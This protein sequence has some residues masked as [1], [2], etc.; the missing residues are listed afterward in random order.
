MTLISAGLGCTAGVRSSSGA[1][2]GGAGATPVTGAGASK[3]GSTGTGSGGHSSGDIGIT[4][5]GANPD[6]AACQ[7][8]DV[9]FTPQTPT[10]FILVDKSG[11]EFIS[12]T[13]GT[14]FNL[15][16]AVEQVVM[17][18]QDQVRFGLGSFVGDHA[19]G[20]CKLNF[21]S[22]PI[23][24]NNYAAIKSAYD[25][26]GPLMPFGSKADTPMAEAIVMVRAALKADTTSGQKYMMVVTDSETDFCDDGNHLCPGDA[27]TGLIQQMY[28]ETPSIGTLVIGLPSEQSQISTPLLKNFANAGAGQP[29][30]LP[31]GSGAATP[32]DVYYQCNGVAPWMSLLTAAGKSMA[33]LTNYSPTAGSAKVYTPS[34]TDTA[35]LTTAISAALNGVRSCTFD[36]S[37]F[38]IDA[39]KLDEAIITLVD[40]ATGRMDVPLDKTSKNGWY[41]TDITAKTNSKGQVMQTATQVQLFGSWCDKLRAQTTTDIK[42]N[43]PCDII[44]DVN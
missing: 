28:A 16:P 42:F 30:V 35:S 22:V 31:P 7:Q 44:I 37:T 2:S 23:A 40:S 15:R 39:D 38:Q 5:S 14:F 26:W 18:L 34:G 12:A 36:L 32:M 43:F 21:Q 33:P 29:V 27:V 10:V 6:A 20:A 41:M 25:S 1:G 13:T 4:G 24:Q 17:Q 3:G 19:T 9:T 11:S 8:K